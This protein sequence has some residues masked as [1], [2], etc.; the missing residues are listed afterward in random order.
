MEV[1]GLLHGQYER[2]DAGELS[3]ECAEGVDD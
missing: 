2:A 1:V 3:V